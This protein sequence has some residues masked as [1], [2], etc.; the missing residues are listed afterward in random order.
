[1]GV[2]AEDVEAEVVEDEDEHGGWNWMEAEV[3]E[4]EDEHG[5]WNWM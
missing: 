1:M 3:V 4:D 2:E 5:G